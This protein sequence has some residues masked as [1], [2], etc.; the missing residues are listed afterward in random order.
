MKSEYAVADFGRTQGLEGLSLQPLGHVRLGLP[1]GNWIAIEEHHDD[2]LVS[3]V[4]RTPHLHSGDMLLALQACEARNPGFD[5]AFQV[6]VQGVGADTVLVVVTR[7]M[8]DRATGSDI[9]AA[10]EACLRWLDR[11]SAEVSASN[12]RA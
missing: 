12:G 10:V 4:A 6:G 3:I 5:R 8:A 2:V 1:D 11:W 7:L 9:G